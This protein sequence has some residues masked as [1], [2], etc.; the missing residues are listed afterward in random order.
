MSEIVEP[1]SDKN[2]SESSILAD[3]GYGDEYVP[4]ESELPSKYSL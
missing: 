4:S 3:N 2:V 1:K